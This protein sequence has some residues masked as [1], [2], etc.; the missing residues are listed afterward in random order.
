MFYYRKE[1]IQPISV[2]RPDAHFGQFCW[3]GSVAPP[4]NCRRPLQYWVQSCHV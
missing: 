2:S 3:S 4:E 1:L